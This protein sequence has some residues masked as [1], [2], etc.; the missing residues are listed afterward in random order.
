MTLIIE[1][2]KDEFLPA[3][4]ALTKAMNAKCRVEKPKLSKSLLKEREELLKN[5]KNGTLNVF[6]SHKDFVKAIDNGK[7]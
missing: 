1:N 5:Y 2:V 7:I 4:K 6:D 3:L